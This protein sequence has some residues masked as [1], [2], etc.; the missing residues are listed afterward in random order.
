MSQAPVGQRFGAQPCNAGRHPRRP[1]MIRPV[2]S[3]IA[4]IEE[5]CS[6]F[7]IGAISRWRSSSTV[8][9]SVKVMQSIG[10]MSTQVVAFDAQLAGKHRLDVAIQ[11]ALG[12]EVGQAF[13]HNLSSTSTRISGQEATAVS[14]NGTR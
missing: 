7:S 2:F 10:Q 13:R 12:F 1:T 8:P 6:R 14:R 3:E 5:S 11:T 4:D 9:S